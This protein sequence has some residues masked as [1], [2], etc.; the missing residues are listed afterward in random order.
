MAR[1]RNPGWAAAML[2]LA[3]FTTLRASPDDEAAVTV[4]VTSADHEL[5]EGY[6][7]LGETATVIAKPGSDLYRFLARQRGHRVTI[8]LVESGPRQLSRLGGER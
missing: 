4:Q 6:F 3:G 5:V 2:V 1:K 8:T 7:S